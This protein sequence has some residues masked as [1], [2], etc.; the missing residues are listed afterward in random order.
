MPETILKML[1]DPESDNDGVNGLIWAFTEGI[2]LLVYNKGT[3]PLYTTCLNA[4][5]SI[6]A[7]ELE[8]FHLRTIQARLHYAMLDLAIYEGDD[9]EIC[10]RSSGI[11]TLARA[12]CHARIQALAYIRKDETDA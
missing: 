3:Y 4:A 12:I 11:S 5:M 7:D 10:F 2:E 8:D 6:G 9:P 1:E